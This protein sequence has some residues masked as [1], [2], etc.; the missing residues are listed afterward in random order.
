MM[1]AFFQ[2]KNRPMDIK[3][4]KGH[5]ETIKDRNDTYQFNSCFYG[6]ANL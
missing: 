5:V 4:K 6:Y 1:I 2:H 3:V